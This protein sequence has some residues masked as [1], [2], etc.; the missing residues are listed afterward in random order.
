[1]A[2]SARARISHESADET[3]VK[4]QHLDVLRLTKHLAAS[5]ENFCEVMTELGTPVA[6]GQIQRRPVPVMACMRVAAA[7]VCGLGD[8]SFFTIVY[9]QLRFSSLVQDSEVLE[10]L[11]IEWRPNFYAGANPSALSDS[12]EENATRERALA[13]VDELIERIEHDVPV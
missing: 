10:K 9:L 6:I 1:M 12:I 13:L 8:S 7:K 2:K 5:D 4:Q 11:G 3:G